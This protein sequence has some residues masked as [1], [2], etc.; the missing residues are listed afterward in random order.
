MKTLKDLKEGDHAIFVHLRESGEE[1]SVTIV[2]K[3][4]GNRIHCGAA[5][6]D[7]ETGLPLGKWR[8]DPT[9]ECRLKPA[10]K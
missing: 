5:V 2:S 10:T 7:R 6:F 1:R 9:V 3:V 4:T 8:S